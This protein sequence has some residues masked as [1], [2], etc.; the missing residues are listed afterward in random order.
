[1]AYLK[2]APFKNSVFA[3]QSIL[4]ARKVI[5]LGMLWRVGDGKNIRDYEDNWIPE[6]Y[7]SRVL[8]T[9]DASLEEATVDILFAG[10]EPRIYGLF[11]CLKKEGE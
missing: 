7:T 8:S 9:W 10:S 1:M 6:T 3:W 2:F 11:G 4:K 5:L